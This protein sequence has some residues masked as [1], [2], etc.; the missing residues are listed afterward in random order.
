MTFDARSWGSPEPDSAIDR[1]E[2]LLLSRVPGRSGAADS[3][4]AAAERM[5]SVVA[6]S[7]TPALEPA[8]VVL[9]S[10]VLHKLWLELGGDRDQIRFLVDGVSELAS[11]PVERFRLRVSRRA[12]TRP[13]LLELPPEL[14]MEAMLAMVRILAPVRQASVWEAGEGG[15]LVCAAHVGGAP[16]GRAR[17]LAHATLEHTACDRPVGLLLALPVTHWD[18]PVAA[19]VARPE[20]GGRARC[21]PALREAAA[22]LGAVLERRTLLDRSAA[23]DASVTATYERRL[24]RIGLDIHD[25]PLQNVAGITGDLGMLRRR[26]AGALSSLPERA[27]ILGGLDDLEA[28]LSEIDAELRHLSH[29]LE[30]PAMLR[31]PFH[32]VLSGE[33]ESFRR[34]TDIRLALDVAGDLENLTASQRI[35]L[36]RIVQESLSNVREHSGAREVHVAVSADRDRLVASVVDDGRGFDAQRALLEA[37]RRGRIGLVGMSERVRLLGGRCDIQSRPGGP[38]SIKVLLPRWRPQSAATPAAAER[39]AIRHE[40]PAAAK[41]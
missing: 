34:R 40:A 1:A 18:R 22:M 25:G 26:L 4:V 35:A 23:G 41:A 7:G 17:E 28:R 20:A 3:I 5:R 2:R 10:D 21:A 6:S 15:R 14:A 19:L 13:T 29:S 33:A 12:L 39:R 32:D 24:T 36:A 38:T 27:L 8:L 11:E 30:S 16:S 31:R 37:A 9:V